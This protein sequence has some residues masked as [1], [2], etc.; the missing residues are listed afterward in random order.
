MLWHF[1]SY[2]QYGPQ[3]SLTLDL[4]EYSK[5]MQVDKLVPSV[6]K[7][8]LTCSEAFM[9]SRKTPGEWN[10]LIQKERNI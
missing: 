10:D 4:R 2:C 7:D 6:I 1:G 9:F 5:K 8:S 3:N